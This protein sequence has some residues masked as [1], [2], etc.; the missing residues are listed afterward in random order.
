MNSVPLAVRGLILVAVSIA[1]GATSWAVYALRPTKEKE[2]SR[3]ERVA[4]KPG[5]GILKIS[6]S[7]AESY[8]IEA[9]PAD[10]VT[11][12][13]R[14]A[15]DGRVL[16]NPSATVDVRAPFAGL[17]LP[18]EPLVLGAAVKAMQ[19]LIKF[20]ARFSQVERIDM[21]AKAVEAVTRAK[22]TEDVVRLRQEQVD[23]LKKLV[24]T[25]GT[26]KVQLDAA[27]IQ[28]KEAE[29]QRDVA[30]AQSKLWEQALAPTG[31]RAIVVTIAAPIQ[32]ETAEI[33]AQPGT[34]VESG[35]LLVR[36]V[37][38][39]RVL[40]RLDFPLSSGFTPPADVEV[41]TPGTLL[42]TPARHRAHLRGAAPNVEVGL[43]R[44]S[45]LYEIVPTDGNGGPNWR[46]GLFVRAILSDPAKASQDAI[47]IPARALLVHQ[48]RPLV[49]VQRSPG[50][51]E[52]REVFPL[53]RD[54]DT[55]YVSA[56]GWGP[57]DDQVVVRNAQAL[58]S[59]EFRSDTDDD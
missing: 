6:R 46:P 42:E 3:Q 7:L 53:D 36:I 59:E 41:E 13:P 15:V 39:R 47:A 38:F 30:V 56:K 45:Y 57:G 8:G 16:A 17:V 28:L 12:H 20:E 55:L 5:G 58:L 51:Y 22:G 50:R 40:V 54:G 18:G 10:A 29:V 1:I 48:G 37:D 44:A 52:R 43:Q 21:Q 26:A 14:L 49:Y 4:E 23:Q 32:G 25:G 2:T 31:A 19:P 11:W 35:Q 34:N 33:G 24:A 27:T 9:G